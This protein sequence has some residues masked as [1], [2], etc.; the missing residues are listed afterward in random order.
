[1]EN[2]ILLRAE[3]IDKRFGLTHAVKDV[4]LTLAR[5]ELGAH[6]GR[7]APDEHLFPDAVR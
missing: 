6:P 3:H 5:G 7:T 1:M 2:N 4:S